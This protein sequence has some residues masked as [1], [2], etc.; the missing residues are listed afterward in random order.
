MEITI[1]TTCQNI[2]QRETLEKMIIDLIPLD[3]E[4]NDSSELELDITWTIDEKID[5]NDDK[6]RKIHDTLISLGFKNKLCFVIEYIPEDNEIG[7][8]FFFGYNAEEEEANYVI[9]ELKTM[10]KRVGKLLPI[11]VNSGM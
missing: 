2:E 8:F 4:Q 7:E 10:T 5:Y 6:W 3:T 9:E 1:S 11:L